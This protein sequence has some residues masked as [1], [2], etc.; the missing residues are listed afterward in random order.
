MNIRLLFLIVVVFI[1]SSCNKP[2][3][4]FGSLVEMNRDQIKAHLDN[5]FIIS[6]CYQVT[7]RRYLV[8]PEG[9]IA[10]KLVP[11]WFE[12]RSKNNLTY[13]VDTTSCEAFSFQCHFAAQKIENIN[14]TVGVF[15]YMKNNIGGHAINVILVNDGEK[16]KP[17]FFEPQT[18]QIVN[19]SKNEL[20]SCR[21][22]YF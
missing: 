9:W 19:L 14:V 10:G 20:A 2:P 7:H 11:A 5:N 6:D 21:F 1:I 4:P 13:N 16:I 15:F 8:P 17:V 12:Y 18:S 3:S 22:F